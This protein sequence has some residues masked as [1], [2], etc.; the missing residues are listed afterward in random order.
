LDAPV[1]WLAVRE[2]HFNVAAL[3]CVR[4]N[5]QNTTNG[6]LLR[7]DIRENEHLT[8]VYDRGHSQDGALRKNDHR[9]GQFL[10]RFSTRRGTARHIDH[11]R[12]MNLDRNFQ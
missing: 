2:F 11:A 1:A 5:F 8:D 7:F 12:T 4:P 3:I 6:I 10:K 9:C